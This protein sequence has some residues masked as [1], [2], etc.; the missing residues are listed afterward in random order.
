M[1][2]DDTDNPEEGATGHLAD[3]IY[4]ET[5]CI[6]IETTSSLENG[7]GNGVCARNNN[8]TTPLDS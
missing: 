7:D 5:I 8:R 1:T 2:V 6:W 3:E 4:R